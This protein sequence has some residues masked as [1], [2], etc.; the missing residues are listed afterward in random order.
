MDMLRPANMT[1]TAIIVSI[2]LFLLIPL[3]VSAQV[4][5]SSE[6][7]LD[8]ET[9][10]I[11]LTRGE[12]V[13]RIVTAFD[14]KNKH[15][16]FINDC[17]EHLS[18]CFFVFNA[19]SNFDGISYKPLLLYPDVNTANRYYD[20]INTATILGLTHG[21]L[22][23]KETPFHPRD[24]MTRIE[25]LKVMLGA[26]NLMDWQEKFELELS[27]QPPLNTEEADK[28]NV[29]DWWY[30]RYLDFALENGIID[31]FDVLKPDGRI[32][33]DDFNAMLMRVQEKAKSV[34]V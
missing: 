29:P 3:N 8:T 24:F 32:S 22:D 9:S 13:G 7:S 28:K 1:V 14:L 27:M 23:E 25:A 34:A 30:A 2:S 15:S 11:F 6:I 19:M 16:K 33:E 18:D 5:Q 20:A 17:F 12:V 21:Y 4:E 31:R 26:A 10:G